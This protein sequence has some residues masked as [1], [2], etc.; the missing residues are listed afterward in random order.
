MEESKRQRLKKAGW[1]VG[2]A[3]DFTGESYAEVQKKLSEG[4]IVRYFTFLE[5]E[6]K[7]LKVYSPEELAIEGFTD[8]GTSTHHAKKR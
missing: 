7:F 1:S 6:W 8:M 2:N 3:E 4:E 5:K